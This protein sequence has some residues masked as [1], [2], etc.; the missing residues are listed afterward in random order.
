[1]VLLQAFK[2]LPTEIQSGMRTAV[3]RKPRDDAERLLVMFKARS[4]LLHPMMQC[5]FARMAEWRVTQVMGERDAFRKILIQ[6][7]RTRKVSAELRYFHR[8]RQARAVMI[9]LPFHKHLRFAFEPPKSISVDDPIPIALQGK[10]GLIFGL[11]YCSP[12]PFAVG[13]GV[14]SQ[15]AIGGLLSF[16]ERFH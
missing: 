3:L 1:M 9:P 6:A 13:H 15:L 2:D 11:C 5:L 10:S 14:R 12:K 8:V 16:C 4:P 7:H